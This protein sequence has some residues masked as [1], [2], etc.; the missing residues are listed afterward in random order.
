MS[1]NT[2]AFIYNATVTRVVDGDTVDIAVDLGFR[3]YHSI[4]T[5]LFGLNAPELHAVGG[6]ESR[7]ALAA[8]I[9]PGS[10]I[11]IQTFKDP[12]DKYGRYLVL[13][14]KPNEPTSINDWLIASGHAVAKFY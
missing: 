13:I 10:P 6:K 3:S 8:K 5:R 7:D 9:P 1:V 2:P 4:M 14:R 12:T 11:V